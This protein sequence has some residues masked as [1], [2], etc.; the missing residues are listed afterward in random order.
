MI[1]YDYAAKLGLQQAR[2]TIDPVIVVVTRGLG[3]A[4]FLI[5]VPLFILA[6]IFTR[7]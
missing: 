1:A 5:G 4:D 2:E 7:R 3:L 6:I